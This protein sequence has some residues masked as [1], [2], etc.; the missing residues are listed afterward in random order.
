M[1][2][3]QMTTTEH[4]QRIRARCVELLAL[5]E[6]RTPGKWCWDMRGEKW[7]DI[8]LG[9]AYDRSGAALTGDISQLDVAEVDYDEQV[10]ESLNTPQ[11]AAFIAACAG[12]A[13]ASWRSTIAAIDGLMLTDLYDSNPRQGGAAKTLNAILAAWPEELL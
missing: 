6:K 8:Q 1:K 13:E 7:F 10:A 9:V 5:A 11:D 4:L 3:S 12:A 2:N